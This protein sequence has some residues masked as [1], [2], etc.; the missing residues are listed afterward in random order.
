MGDQV[1]IFVGRV[2]LGRAEV[3]AFDELHGKALN[4]D[5]GLGNYQPSPEAD[6]FLVPAAMYLPGDGSVSEANKSVVAAF[7]G[8]HF[9]RAS[10]TARG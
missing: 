4:G 10:A 9:S 2:K 1:D 7:V 8:S 3:V 5:I 6:S